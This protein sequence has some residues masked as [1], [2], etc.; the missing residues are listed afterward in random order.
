MYLII[1]CEFIIVNALK[2][3]RSRVD[4]QKPILADF[5]FNLFWYLRITID[6]LE[7]SLSAGTEVVE[8]DKKSFAILANTDK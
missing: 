6:A 8:I 2:I 5:L 1:Y 7:K 3:F 4:A